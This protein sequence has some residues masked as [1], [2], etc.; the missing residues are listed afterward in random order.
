[1]VTQQQLERIGLMRGDLIPPQIAQ[2]LGISVSEVEQA[3]KQIE[4]G[5]GKQCMQCQIDY[6]DLVQLLSHWEL[7]ME[8]E[9]FLEPWG[10]DLDKI[11]KLSKKLTSVC[12]EDGSEKQQ[13]Q[14]VLN[15]L[16]KVEYTD[17]Q[18][19]RKLEAM[20]NAL[21]DRT[22]NIALNDKLT[23]WRK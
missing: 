6:L 1:M 5:D 8:I 4:G 23:C 19:T 18:N 22:I 13:F 14:N 7:R 16:I 3:I 21:L 10:E 9:W 17:P 15:E 20:I 11:E 2:R 12:I